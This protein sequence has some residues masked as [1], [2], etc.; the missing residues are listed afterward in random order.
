MNVLA[1]IVI[2]TNLA[3]SAAYDAGTRCPA[4][5]SYDLEPCEIVVTNRV[6]IPFAPDPRVQDCATDEDYLGSGYD[7]GHMAPASDFNFDRRSLRRP[8]SSRTS[9]RRTRSSTEASGRSSSGR[10]ATSPRPA[11]STSSR[12]P[13][14][15]TDSRRTASDVS[16]FPMPSRRSPSNGSAFVAGSSSI[17]APGL[18]RCDK[19]RK[20]NQNE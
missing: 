2:L 10:S 6:P 4:W 20:V 12:F 1:S 15:S 8:T 9:A 18:S 5:V 16:R 17:S 3:Y 14:S 19:Q 11:L 13:Y 7:R